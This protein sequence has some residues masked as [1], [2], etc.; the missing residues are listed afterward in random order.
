MVLCVVM[1]VIDVMMSVVV[2]Y[3]DMVVVVFVCWNSVVIM[4]GVKLLLMMLVS[5]YVSDEFV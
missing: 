4:S 3:S 5:V 1:S 2:M